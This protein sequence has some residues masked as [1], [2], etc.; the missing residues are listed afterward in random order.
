MF[1]KWYLW[2]RELRKWLFRSCEEI[3]KNKLAHP[4]VQNSNFIQDFVECYAKDQ[5]QDFPKSCVTNQYWIRKCQ[6]R[7][8]IKIEVKPLIKIYR[9][10]K[11]TRG[12]NTNRIRLGHIND[13]LSPVSLF[14]GSISIFHPSR[15]L[16]GIL[17][18]NC[19]AL[20]LYQTEYKKYQAYRLVSCTIKGSQSCVQLPSFSE[21][22]CF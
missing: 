4:N 21:A 13:N 5:D 20:S 9:W 12:N 19:C 15:S 18:P 2:I 10:Y 8:N 6:P 22:W 17:Q 3:S 7:S 16:G 11:A 14:V 1:R